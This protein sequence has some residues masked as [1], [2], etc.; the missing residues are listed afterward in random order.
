MPFKKLIPIP[1][2][3]I[4]ADTASTG[5][6]AAFVEELKTMSM[7]D[8]V[9]MI[10]SNLIEIALKIL[11]ALII[12]WIG[13]WV[14]HRIVKITKRVLIHRQIEQSLSSF[15]ISLIKISLTLLL[16]FTTIGVLGINTTSFLAIFASAGLAV[17][18]ALSGTLQ[19]FAGG[20]MI[21]FLKPYKVG[22]FIEA[23]GYTGTV[24]EI[25]LFSTLVNTVDNKTI[26]IPNGGLSTGIINNF[27]KED[28]RRVDWTFGIAYGDDYDHAKAIINNM[29]MTDPRVLHDPTEPFIALHSLANSSVNIVVRAWTASENYW[30]LYFDINEKV[31]K[32]FP[33]EGLHIPFPQ[34]D[35]H[36]SKQE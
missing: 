30:D 17:G 3:T 25:S 24:K 6:F 2:D 13:R 19:N 20:V 21:L 35:V 34:M 7:H 8:I 15:L 1:A 23:Q 16:I 14:I 12:Y 32:T 26:I 31:Y 33:G 10:A 9:S 29:L 36:I 18:M 4:P 22:D 28:K 27:S 11:L 5:K